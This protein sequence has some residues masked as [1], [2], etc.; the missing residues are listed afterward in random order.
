MPSITADAT[1]IW[2]NWYHRAARWPATTL[3][4]P[5]NCGW[6]LKLSDLK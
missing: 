3:K 5:Y 4:A 2:A 1:T 6:W